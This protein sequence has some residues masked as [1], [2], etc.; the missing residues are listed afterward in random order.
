MIPPRLL[1]AG[2]MASI[3]PDLDVLAFRFG[4]D[5]GHAAGHR[6]MTHS[7]TFAVVLGALASLFAKYL[8]TSRGRSFAFVFMAAASH[9][10]LDMLTNGGLGAALFW[11]VS[12]SRLFFPMHPVEVSPLSLRRAFGGAGARVLLSELLWVWLPALAAFAGLR[13]AKR[14]RAL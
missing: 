9:P 4:V 6:G 14:P 10:L 13:Y 8:N 2:V 3:L 12:D 11:P 1:V 7:L 5:Y